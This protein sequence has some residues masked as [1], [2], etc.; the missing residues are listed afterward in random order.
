MLKITAETKLENENEN[1][2]CLGLSDRF[3]SFSFNL[4][5]VLNIFCNFAFFPFFYP[6]NSEIASK[7]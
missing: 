7:F 6:F 2:V 1:L 4:D 3:V 5:G